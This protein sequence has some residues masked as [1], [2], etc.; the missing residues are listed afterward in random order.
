MP[1]CD[2][3]K[4]TLS[5]TTKIH[6]DRYSPIIRQLTALREIYRPTFDGVI[7]CLFNDRAD[8]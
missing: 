3:Y 4:E 6:L 7:I 1:G 2:D 8:S 5:K